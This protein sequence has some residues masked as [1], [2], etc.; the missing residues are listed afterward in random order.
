M[1]PGG[2]YWAGKDQG[3]WGVPKGEYSPGE[4][5][6]D[7]AQ[8][9]FREETGFPPQRSKIAGDPGFPPQRSKIAGDPGFAPGSEFVDLGSI[10]QRSGKVVRAWAFKGDCDPAELVSNTC[11]IEWPPRSRRMLEI[12]EVAEGRWFD[13][14]QARPYIRAEQEPLLDRLQEAVG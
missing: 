6:L 8:R 14:A 10:R 9:E 2:P 5:P 1:R 4:D 11:Q 3:A 7:A 12:P 13:L